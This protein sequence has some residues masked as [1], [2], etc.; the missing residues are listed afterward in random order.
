[1]LLLDELNVIADP[2]QRGL[3]S[4]LRTCFLD[5]DAYLCYTS[6]WG[7]CVTDALGSRG[8][9]S[10]RGR[11]A[12]AVARSMCVEDLRR[13]FKDKGIVVNPS[14]VVYYCGNPALIYSV[15]RGFTPE[16]RFKEFM[17]PSLPAPPPKPQLEAKD[18]F[19]QFCLGG[20]TLPDFRR[21]TSIQKEGNDERAVWPLCYAKPALYALGLD[22]LANLADYVR[23][24]FSDP[25][26]NSGLEWEYLARFAL[27]IVGYCATFRFL[28]DGEHFILGTVPSY[29][30]SP[31]FNL[32]FLDETIQTV[33]GVWKKFEEEAKKTKGPLC[34][35][36]PSPNI[37]PFPSLTGFLPFL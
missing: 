10:Y 5:C 6:H 19:S 9:L 16:T 2:P 37:V 21:F 20:Y 18:F 8:D 35:L 1:M 32:I 26:T 22:H 24:A 33:A 28:T 25:S 29:A 30:N 13:M 15:K 27:A 11:Y 12:V 3:A 7:F 34:L 14:E 31:E 17:N 23:V 36:V 4:L